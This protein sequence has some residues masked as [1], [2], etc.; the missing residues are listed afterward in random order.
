MQTPFQ[1]YLQL[2]HVERGLMTLTSSNALC[3][4]DSDPRLCS[5]SAVVG[6]DAAC[7]TCGSFIDARAMRACRLIRLREQTGHN[8]LGRVSRWRWSI[9]C[10]STGALETDIWHMDPVDWARTS[11][12]VPSSP[13]RLWSHPG[14]KPQEF[15]YLFREID[16]W[17]S[18]MLVW[19]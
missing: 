17:P 9:S 7:C 3:S 15:S 13:I 10:Y 1:S 4:P 2:P 14:H 19:L 11:G 18:W 16:Y 8:Q 5:G 12:Q 6:I